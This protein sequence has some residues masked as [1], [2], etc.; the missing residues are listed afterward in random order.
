[1]G[2]VFEGGV[3]LHVM[4]EVKEVDVLEDAGPET[5]AAGKE[6]SEDA[7]VRVMDEAGDAAAV[8]GGRG[9]YSRA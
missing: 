7:G 3:G 6:E 4:A 2:G 9:E 8:D 5:G 1:M